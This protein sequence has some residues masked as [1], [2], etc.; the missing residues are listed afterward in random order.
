LLIAERKAT[1]LGPA[2]ARD[3]HGLPM[4]IWF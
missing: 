2:R 1:R 4:N 3:S